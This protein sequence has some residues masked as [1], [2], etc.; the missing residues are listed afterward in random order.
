MPTLIVRLLVMLGLSVL[1]G[2]GCSSIPRSPGDL[3]HRSGCSLVLAER[4]QVRAQLVMYVHASDCRDR[5]GHLL[6][7]AQAVDRV[8]HAVWQSLELPVD[9]IRVS[10]SAP[11]RSPEGAPTTIARDELTERFGRGPSGVVWPV[12]DRSDETIWIV[13]PLAYLTAVVT[14]LLLVRG[15]RR[16]GLVIVLLRR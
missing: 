10:V 16:V 4:T 14:M 12:R 9:A 11:G 7:R 13:L 1:F 2:L 5:N 8:A 15:L 3:D 6:E